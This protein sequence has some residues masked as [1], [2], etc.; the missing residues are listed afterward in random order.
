[1]PIPA[2]QQSHTQL[3]GEKEKKEKI[4][5]PLIQFRK[6]VVSF[7]ITV[8]LACFGLL[9]RTQAVSPPPDGDYPGGNTAEGFKALFSLN[10][11]N[12]GFNT[13]IGFSSLAAN[14]TGSFNTALG[15]GALDLN[16]SHNNTAV[17]AAALLLNTTGDGNTATGAAALLQNSTGRGN[18]ATGGAALSFNTTGSG[19]TAVGAQALLNSLGADLNTAVGVNAL[20]TPPA[21]Q[22]RPSA[23]APAK[24]TPG[25]SLQR[26]G[27]TPLATT[28]RPWAGR[29][30]GSLE[31]S[32]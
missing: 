29:P 13:A 5:N 7:V 28:T 19:N 12:G 30:S 4:M 26:S 25:F 2:P 18:T 9:P 17:G 23:E 32:G 11:Q 6:T 14:V 3:S 1:L 21:A 8:V 27:V 16:T 15:A 20:R 24:L 10:T 22:I 31:H